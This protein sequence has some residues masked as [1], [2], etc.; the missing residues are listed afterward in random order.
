MLSAVAKCSLFKNTLFVLTGKLD[1]FKIIIIQQLSLLNLSFKTAQLRFLK[2]WVRY[3]S[4]ILSE[5]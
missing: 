5:S 3:L 2:W 1:F 4:S